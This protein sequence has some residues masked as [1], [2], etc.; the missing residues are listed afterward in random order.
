MA[1][2]EGEENQVVAGQPVSVVVTLEREVEE[3]EEEEGAGGG[4]STTAQVVA[5]LY[6]KAKLEAWWLIVGDPAKNSLLFIKRVNNIT[7]RTKTKLNF[8]APSEPGDHDLKLYFICDSYMGADQEY[9]LS[10][11][12]LPGEEGSESS[13]EE[14][15]GSEGEG[16]EVD[17]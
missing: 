11:S 8:A 13:S 4:G 5:P 1:G 16:M 14:E 12:V 2:A 7:R 17:K 3:D 15:S 10:L 9:D 6:P